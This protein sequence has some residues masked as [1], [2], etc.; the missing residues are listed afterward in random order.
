MLQY[1]EASTKNIEKLSKFKSL[2]HQNVERLYWCET[3]MYKNLKCFKVITDYYPATLETF[4]EHFKMK[5]P[6]CIYYGLCGLLILQYI[7]EILSAT[8]YLLCKTS[9]VELSIK[10][11]YV[12]QIGII[13]LV[14]SNSTKSLETVKLKS[15]NDINE[16]VWTFF[17]I[18]FKENVDEN[19][20]LY[21]DLI[22]LKESLTITKQ[23]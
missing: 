22:N 19:F 6:N 12:N 3:V 1:E 5:N 18:L 4:V 17:T 7:Y 14:T 13:S 20:K 23:K 9:K 16:L 15:S 8:E 10:D 11:I 2:N 21:R